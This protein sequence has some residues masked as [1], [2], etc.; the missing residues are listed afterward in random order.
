MKR[1]FFITIYQKEL[2]IEFSRTDT[3]TVCTPANLL[4]FKSDKNIVARVFEINIKLFI[5]NIGV[6][7]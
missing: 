4:E 2:K 5:R 6:L 1:N 7:L 3:I